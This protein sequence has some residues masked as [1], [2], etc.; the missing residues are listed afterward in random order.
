MDF[1]CCF[2]SILCIFKDSAAVKAGVVF[3]QLYFLTGVLLS[4]L[5]GGVVFKSGAVFKQIR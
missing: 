4:F 2:S 3:F 5:K 1:Y